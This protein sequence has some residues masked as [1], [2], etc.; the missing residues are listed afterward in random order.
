MSSWPPA[1]SY[2]TAYADA[3]QRRLDSWKSCAHEEEQPET[4]ETALKR[5]YD[6]LPDH[7]PFRFPLYIKEVP[8]SEDPRVTKKLDVKFKNKLH[9]HI[10]QAPP[11]YELARDLAEKA[12]IEYR[13][14]SDFRRS[15]RL[16]VEYEST[17][18]SHILPARR[19]PTETR[20]QMQH[21]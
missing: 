12:G 8:S 3:E 13:G 10:V 5:D 4:L 15:C 21:L 7:E 2:F 1:Q 11:K 18:P 20:I 19:N 16:P 14:E 9:I 17:R 6:L